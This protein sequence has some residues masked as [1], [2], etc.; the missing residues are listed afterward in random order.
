MESSS[1]AYSLH[2]E[3]ISNLIKDTKGNHI[4]KIHII[5]DYLLKLSEANRAIALNAICETYGSIPESSN[6]KA[7]SSPFLE[8]V[9]E[10]SDEFTERIGLDIQLL[11]EKNYTEKTFYKK[12]AEYIFN[13]INFQSEFEAVFALCRFILD[14]RIP[15]YHYKASQTIS[16]SE[17][18]FKDAYIRLFEKRK[19]IQHFMYRSFNNKTTQASILLELLGI[20]IPN[21]EDIEANNLYKEQ[22]IL[23][24]EI[25]SPKF[26]FNIKK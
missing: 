9:N 11:I 23:M 8:R 16:L 12:A 24:S 4:A 18:D 26:R 22:L 19:R 5:Y 6:A 3:K 25:I 15:Y 13:K 10:I 20:G 7:I 17:N 2:K 14:I 21:D 1:N